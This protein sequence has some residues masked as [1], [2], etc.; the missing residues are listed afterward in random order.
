MFL[1]C[2][3]VKHGT[4]RYYYCELSA[5]EDLH[6]NVGKLCSFFLLKEWVSESLEV[7]FLVTVCVAVCC[8]KENT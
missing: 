7:A 3:A 6:G 5:N 2:Y 8:F 4:T 1:S